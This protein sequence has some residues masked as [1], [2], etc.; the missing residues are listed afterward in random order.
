ML[1]PNRGGREEKK[2]RGYWGYLAVVLT[3]DFGLDVTMDDC[4]AAF[5]P[6]WGVNPSSL[7]HLYLSTSRFL[8]HKRF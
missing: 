3:A 1:S 2:V 5:R 6:F 7:R 8:N 4:A